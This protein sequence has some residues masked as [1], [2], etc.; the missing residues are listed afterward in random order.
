MTELA[1]T[2]RPGLRLPMSWETYDSLDFD[3]SLRGAEYVNGALLLPPG[4]PDL[5]HHDAI[6]YLRDQLRPTLAAGE[7]TTSGF[8]WKP[9]GINAEYIPD[10]MVF[11]A[12]EDRRRFVGQPLLCV[13]VTSGNRSRDL[14]EK[15]N[16]YAAAGLP[17]YWI[18]DRKDK[19]L[20][21]HE[22]RGGVLVETATHHL[23][24]RRRKALTVTATYAGRPVDV[25]LVQ[26]FL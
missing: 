19:A 20:R 13:E 4:A 24:L 18:V 11:V 23:P 21:C 3:E 2:L 12:D 14:V 16:Y 8:A 9:E 26:L 5:G 1:T 10:V 17:D 7:R 25:D 15:R 22:L 6:D